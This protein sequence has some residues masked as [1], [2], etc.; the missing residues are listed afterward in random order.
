MRGR[1]VLPC[2]RSVL[3]TVGSL[4][5]GRKGCAGCAEMQGRRGSVNTEIRREQKECFCSWGSL[6][7]RMSLL[8]LAIMFDSLST[9]HWATRS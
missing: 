1:V 6:G 2:L 3:F 8:S 7:L 5:F 9:V 4:V